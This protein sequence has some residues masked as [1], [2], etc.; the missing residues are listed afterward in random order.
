MESTRDQR[1]GLVMVEVKAQ[2]KVK[3]MDLMMRVLPMGQRKRY[4]TDR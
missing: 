3:S 1:M 2:V 4:K